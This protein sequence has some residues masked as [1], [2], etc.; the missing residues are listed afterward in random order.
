MSI[1]P[2]VSLML[3]SY[4][5]S[6]WLAEGIESALRQ[7]YEPKEVVVI[8]NHSTENNREIAE[9]HGVRFVDTGSNTG[10]VGLIERAIVEAKGDY[11][12]CFS[13]EDP[14]MNGIISKQMALFEANPCLEVVGSWYSHITSD[15]TYVYTFETKWDM[16]AIKDYCCMSGCFI[17][18]RSLYDKVKWRDVEVDTI[19]AYQDW[20]LWLQCAEKSIK[21]AVVTEVGF[22]YRNHPSNTQKAL[23]IHNEFKAKL[24][25]MNMGAYC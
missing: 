10:C 24:R 11:I 25:E 21:G 1:R 6:Q 13:H 22:K 16:E 18:K 23:N 2:L 15:G 4:N 19:K 12:M 3:M 14:L 7:E 8:D 17:G 9:K 20:D 5:K